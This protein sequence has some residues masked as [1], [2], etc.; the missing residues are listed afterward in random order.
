MVP[1]EAGIEPISRM[2]GV[3]A[4]NVGGS[5]R[6]VVPRRVYFGLILAAGFLFFVATENE[7]LACSSF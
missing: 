6:P 7:S 2:M 4:M 1:A 3:D 5:V